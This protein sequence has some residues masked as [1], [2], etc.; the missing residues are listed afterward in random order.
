MGSV[1]VDTDG[2]P[3]AAGVENTWQV[4]PPE[5]FGST[6]QS[7]RHACESLYEDGQG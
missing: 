3:F 5:A 4:C 2:N 6:I 7:M 1:S